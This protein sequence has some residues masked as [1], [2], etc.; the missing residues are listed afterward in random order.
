MKT[1]RDNRVVKVERRLLVG[2]RRRLAEA[3]SNSEELSKL[4]T[5]FI[6]R[7]NLTIQHGSAYVSRRSACPGPCSD[8]V[9]KDPYSSVYILK[10]WT[11]L[12][13]A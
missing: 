6:E 9:V 3:L 7:P 10:G 2:P 8:A 12:L 11:P 1:W 5:S 4:N 13:T